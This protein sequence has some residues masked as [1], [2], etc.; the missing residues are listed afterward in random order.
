V[1]GCKNLKRRC[2][3]RFQ[4]ASPVL[5]DAVLVGEK[6]QRDVPECKDEIGTDGSDIFLKL[7]DSL[8]DGR[9]HLRLQQGFE[10]IIR[11]TYVYYVSDKALIPTNVDC[12]EIVV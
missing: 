3:G 8:I 7:Q 5:H 9:V 6:A 2:K 1:V 4:Y 12:A 10:L 11:R